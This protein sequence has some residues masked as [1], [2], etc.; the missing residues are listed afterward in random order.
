MFAAFIYA[1]SISLYGYIKGKFYPSFKDDCKFSGS[2][3]Y[4]YMM[5]IELNPRIGKFFDM[6]LFHNGRPGIVA[7]TLINLS[8][9]AAQYKEIGYVANSMI[10]VNLFHFVYVFDFFLNEGWYLRT[11]DITHDHFGW[12]YGLGDCVYLPIMYTL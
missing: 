5:G 12:Y 1:Y 10:L 6:K 7:W 11:I 9:A 4:D 3:V 2:V 8:F